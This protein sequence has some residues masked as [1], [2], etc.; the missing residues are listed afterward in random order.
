M[1]TSDGENDALGAVGGGPPPAT[2]SDALLPAKGE[3]EKKPSSLTRNLTS[4]KADAMNK[5]LKKA[6]SLTGKQNDDS[7][8]RKRG[9]KSKL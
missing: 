8:N 4:V 2:A 9:I 6:S 3:P 5:V 7:D 1:P